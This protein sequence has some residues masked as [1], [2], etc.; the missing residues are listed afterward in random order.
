MKD[1]EE[2]KKINSPKEQKDS[3]LIKDSNFLENE[4]YDKYK[5][6]DKTISSI[7]YQDLDEK[8]NR[9]I[10][11]KKEDDIKFEEKENENEDNKKIIDTKEEHKEENKIEEEKK[12]EKAKIVEEEKKV[13]EEK[14]IEEEKK[15]NNENKQNENNIKEGIKKLN[16]FLNL[17]YKNIFFSIMKKY[18]LFLLNIIKGTDL[19]DNKIF[20]IKI[21]ENRKYFLEILINLKQKEVE[22][23]EKEEEEKIE[24]EKK[25]KELKEKEES[26][27]EESEEESEEEEKEERE[28]KEREEREKKEKEEREK[29]EK[30][31]REKKE[32][33]EREK[34]EKEEKEK[35][36]KEER[37]KKEKEE[38][39]KKEKEERAKKEKE[40]REK[41]EKEKIDKK[42]EEKENKIKKRKKNSKEISNIR[43]I[44][45]KK[46]NKE[47]EKNIK[48][49]NININNLMQNK[50][51]QEEINKIKLSNITNDKYLTAQLKLQKLEFKKNRENEYLN[52][53]NKQ[54][55]KKKDLINIIDLKIEKQSKKVQ[56][57][58]N[59]ETEDLI[60][61][62]KS[63][64][65]NNISLES[66]TNIENGFEI[67][68]F[69]IKK[70]IS[71][72]KMIFFHNL[73]G[74]NGK[75]QRKSKNIKG[76]RFSS[77]HSGKFS[78]KKLLDGYQDYYMKSHN[79][80]ERG[81][82]IDKSVNN[83]IIEIEE[84][85]SIKDTSFIHLKEPDYNKPVDK[86]QLVEY[87]L[88]Y[89]E[90]FFRNDVFLY[91]VE[92]IEDK[93]EAEIQKEMNRLALKRKL[94]EKKKLK[95]V[96]ILKKLDT[97]DLQKEIDE[98]QKA[99]EKCKRKEEPKVQLEMNNTEGF[100]HNGRMLGNYFKGAEEMTVPR[101]SMESEK[102]T[103]AKEVID[104]KLLRKEEVARRYFDYC[105]CLEKRKKINKFLVYARYYCRFFVDN[106]IFDNISLLIIITNTILILISDP[107]DPNNI[108]NRSDN[109]FLYFYTIEA[110]L[111]IISFSFYAAEDAYIKDYWNILDFFVVIVGWISFILERAMN[112]TKIS[113]LAGL[114][115]FRILRPFK[116]V[117]RFK[118]LKKLVTALL[119]SIGRLGETSIVLFFFFIIFAIAGTQMWQGLFY[120]RCMSVNYGYLVST[121]GDEGMC[122]F[123]SNCEEYNS[124]GNTFICAK[125]YRNPNSGVT[126]FDNT[127]T[128]LVTV[129]VMVTLEGW[130][131]LFTYVSKTFKDKIYINPIIIFC[132]FHVF[133]F[134]AAFYLINLFLAVTNSEFEHIEVS[135]KQLKEK[136]SFFKLIQNKYDSKERE[137]IERKEKE[138]QLKANNKKKSDE[139]LRELYYK[140]TDEAFHINKNKRNIPILYS[141]VKD[142][143]IMTNKNPE[144]LYLQSLQI[145]EEETFL[146]K[147][148]KR[149]QKEIDN[150]IKK[151]KKEIKKENNNN[152]INNEKP[153][154]PE[155]KKDEILNKIKATKTFFEGI[156]K[157]INKKI[158]K[159]NFNNGKNE[160][161]II[162]LRKNK[163][164]I[165]N[166]RNNLKIDNE[167]IFNESKEKEIIYNNI[168]NNLRS[169]MP[170]VIETSI[171]NTLD[172]LLKENIKDKTK[173][174]NEN[175]AKKKKKVEKTSK[176]DLDIVLM[177]DLS[178]EKEIRE[179]KKKKLEEKNKKEKKEDQKAKRAADRKNTQIKAVPKVTGLSNIEIKRKGS[180]KFSN[181][182]KEMAVKKMV[183]LPEDLPIINDLSLS[184]I[185]DGFD[186]K[187][188][189]KLKKKL[190]NKNLLLKQKT[191][192]ILNKRPDQIKKENNEKI[193]TERSLISKDNEEV[194]PILR[195]RQVLFDIPNNFN[196]K[197]EFKK[198][199]SILNF[200]QKQKRENLNEE[201]LKFIEKKFEKIKNEDKKESD[202]EKDNSESIIMDNED[203]FLNFVDNIQKKENM[204]TIFKKEN[205][206]QV[207]EE[208]QKQNN[209]DNKSFTKSI[210]GDDKSLI[211]FYDEVSLDDIKLLKNEIPNKKVYKV[212]YLQNEN[213]RKNL[214]L[215]KLT[216]LIRS[217]FFDRESIN[218]DINLTTKQQS[219]HFKNMNKKLNKLLFVDVKKIRGR[220]NKEDDLNISHIIEF[221]N[222]DKILKHKQVENEEFKNRKMRRFIKKETQLNI[223]NLQINP[224]KEIMQGYHEKIINDIE[225]EEVKEFEKKENEMNKEKKE[226]E[227][228]IDKK[229]IFKNILDRPEKQEGMIDFL[230]S[231]ANLLGPKKTSER[232]NL[233]SDNSKKEKSNE[234][235]SNKAKL[236]KSDSNLTNLNYFKKIKQNVKN[237]KQ[238]NYENLNNKKTYNIQS[239]KGAVFIFKA[240]SIEKNIIK[241]PVENSKNFQINE[242]NK[243]YTD[244]LTVTQELIPDNLRGKKFYLNYL[245]N[246]S[247]K[248]LKVK[249]NFKVDH[250][251]KEILGNKEKTFKKKPLPESNEAFFVFNDKKLELKKYKYMKIKDIEYSHKDL[252][253]LTHKLNFLPL[254]V[255]EIMPIR[256]RNFGKFAVGREINPGALGT[257]PTSMRADNFKDLNTTRS[258]KATTIKPRNETHIIT[259]SSFSKHRKYQEEIMFR[260][261]IF[262]RIYKKINEFNYKTLS[263]Y[264]L[265][266]DNL[267]YQLV[268]SKRKDEL[269]KKI[270]DR[271]REKENR[272]E[273]KDEIVN[274]LEFDLKTNSRRYIKWSGSD[275]LCHKN[276]DENRKKWNKLINSLEDFNMI[277]WHKNT[278]IMRFQKLR[279]AFYILATNDYFDYAILGIVIINSVFMALDGNLLK[280]EIISKIDLSNYAFNSIFILEYIV[281]FIGLGPLVYYSDA[282]TYLDTLIIAFAILDMCTPNEDTGTSSKDK[283]RNVSSKL[284][285]LRVFR[286]FRVIRLTKVLRRLKSMRFII[287]SIKKAL[288]NVSY[289]IAILIMFILIFQL[290]GMSLL[291]GN[292]HYQS[293]F[294]GFYTT[295]QILTMENWNSLLYE[296]WPMNYFS[297]FYFLAWIFI[298]NYVIF[299]LFISILLQSFDEP[300][301]EDDDDL[302]YDEKVEKMYLL[303]AYLNMVK[304]SAFCNKE[305]KLKAYRKKFDKNDENDDIQE[306]EEESVN[307]SKDFSNSKISNSNFESYYNSSSHNDNISLEVS[308]SLEHNNSRIIDDNNDE[309]E[310]YEH[311]TTI[312]ENMQHWKKVNILFAKNDCENSLYFLPQTNNF[313][314][315]CMKLIL[316]KWFDRF[317]LF[318]ILCSTTRLVVDTFVSGFEFVLTFDIL[319]AIFNI[320]FL[321]ECLLKIFAMGFV[322]DE[323]SYLRDNWNKMDIIIV[324]CSFFDFQNLFTKYFTSSNGNSSVQFLK[325][326]RLL[327]TLR[328]LRFISHN[329]QLKLII[330]SLFDSILPICNAL[331]IVIVVYYMFSIVGISLFYTNMHNCYILNNEGY[332]DLAIQ[333]FNDI[334]VDFEVDDDMISI[335]NF[336]ADRYNGIMDTGPAFKFSNI[337]TS[338][339]TSYCLSTMEGWPD[340]MNSY[341]IY[342]SYYGIYF[343][344][345][346][347]VVAYFFLNLFTGIMFRYFNEAFK[348]EQKI[349]EDDKK[350]PK[351]Y[352]FLTQICS[353]ETHY[354]VWK[355]PKKGTYAYFLRELADSPYLDNF[356][357]IIIFLN[358]V[359]MALNFEGSSAGFNLFL[360]IVNYIFTGIFILECILKLLGYGI[361][362]YFHSGWN[363]FDFFVVISSIVDLAVANVEGFDASFLKSFQIIRVLRVLRI[364]R[365][366]RLIKSLKGLEK[367]IQTLSWSLTALANVLLLMLIFFCIFA[368]LGC[369]FYDSIFYKDYKDVFVY[370]NEY[371]N[372]DN[373]YYSFLLVF[374]CATG[375][376]WNNI[377]MELAFIDP[378]V[379]SEAY[380]YIYFIISNFANSIIM[381]NLFLMVTLQQYD[382]FTNKN[383]NPI[384]K[385]ESFLIDFNNSWN[386][387]SDDEDEGFRIKKIY[388]IQFFMDFNWKKLN[389][390]EQGKLEQVKK[391]ITELKLRTDDDDYIYYHDVI[392]KVINRQMGS[393]ID[394]NN[395]DNNTI[396]K[397]EIK[398]Q[399]EIKQMINRYIKKHS[400]H[401]STKIKF[402]IPFNPLTSHLYF[403][404]S[405]IYLKAFINFYKENCEYYKNIDEQESQKKI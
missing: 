314:I 342:E 268:D 232:V 158:E 54:M 213:I 250:W 395:K 103:G 291:S 398:V 287:V 52:I 300:E 294:I 161:K 207:K 295:Y 337:V 348:R 108:G 101:F 296:I 50:E 252:T 289:I 266:E 77:M 248:D 134:I 317:I 352:D 89:K 355:K 366:L 156:N 105:C 56:Q 122:S 313:R 121:S 262:E 299:N 401:K 27:E 190:T 333:S 388:V 236:R 378:E 243:I 318:L 237:R 87:D 124:Y 265:I 84:D 230:N 7:S 90:Q 382:E 303:P 58:K 369:Y 356:I 111:K 187:Q 391:Y 6:N 41:K 109:Y 214:E 259:S 368:I 290:L 281:K 381:L 48:E 280:P 297:F 107:T 332:F 45:N 349:A 149:Q 274:I 173:D 66:R 155:K 347:L 148:I 298:G 253:Y 402:T 145:D 18:N 329:V 184:E 86:S 231:D 293:F 71:N 35:K 113:G 193:D 308:R 309:E 73:L 106:W 95:E 285:F 205:E 198:P 178:F 216:Q 307:D 40:E 51:N 59:K 279:Y 375:E 386:K 320:I 94:I 29:K 9:L 179:K 100:V 159:E 341:T 311:L 220:F 379:V 176:K 23:K 61:S 166:K 98:L 180:K 210:L 335:S 405:Y 241:Y 200:L 189:F 174:F 403:K 88:F 14:K 185:E 138:R 171:D 196:V 372:V 147:D 235:P 80:H 17:K 301:E 373:F 177:E 371:Y 168:M 153:N 78:K 304:K 20:K 195:E 136:K 261:N 273:I 26:E 325:V 72:N 123:D 245:Y 229:Q 102:E 81:K 257:K 76:R 239:K 24:K 322:M 350:A 292:Y 351:Y 362:P 360:T 170:E 46:V 319:D 19:L 39:E 55:Q 344:V 359:F 120:R 242:E 233:N 65:I 75:K 354:V 203:S 340:I 34:K 327:R 192:K 221:K 116:T 21:I 206:V 150:L 212:D 215:N 32:K 384:E 49:N 97:K 370:I 10:N 140:I 132:Y 315:F 8:L 110:F 393:L 130:T 165:P 33:E 254:N 225:N 79:I 310:V 82:E 202:K 169:I 218:T 365:V 286:I 404:I 38:R 364:T 117:K 346:N 119:A 188:L 15:V 240:K 157:K 47:E 271:N 277:I 263:H 358:L 345:A 60:S 112:G 247:D 191:M 92:N 104:F 99:Y 126:N 167:E 282:F 163:S 392:Y 284:S 331:F 37:E 143:Y 367:L 204:E 400:K 67:L 397:K 146:G 144:D 234:P 115:A 251:I 85:E 226:D 201:R 390:P 28:K 183:R 162:S 255:L 137:K 396:F 383:Y 302:T 128:A 74:K 357:M 260:K 275:V 154:E 223:A 219:N 305:K 288:S 96:N 181:L 175:L 256:L 244:P 334:L 267:Y 272:I 238:R 182:D 194:E 91:D 3:N 361:R 129:F 25:D 83:N 1:D 312:A 380:A 16:D 209:E 13:K 160:E 2:N 131:D 197:S 328:P 57:I 44:S 93:V 306:D 377:M 114:R 385:F 31:E 270:S 330:T 127:L 376:N 62:D 324:L 389:F 264:F 217:S 399:R 258:G 326:I 125:G 353:A 374:R 199:H 211:S 228:D 278:W 343:I 283:M 387:Y 246:I 151:K 172:F 394:R 323:G 142:M 22:K 118:G 135:R 69:T 208:S 4:G 224:I 30:E 338:F 186:R 64:S 68:S 269:I 133:V 276:E 222:Y 36:E 363:R 139:T 43:N 339:I 42:E 321:L 70:N 164:I 316:N 152:N 141:T 63:M 53:I 227:K 11:E 336:C 249:D 12:I 5:I